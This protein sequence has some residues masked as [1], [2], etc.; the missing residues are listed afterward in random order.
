[1]VRRRRQSISKGFFFN[2]W[3][4]L[5]EDQGSLQW[6]SFLTA[7]PQPYVTEIQA[8]SFSWNLVLHFNNQGYD[9]G[10][11]LSSGWMMGKARSY[12][13]PCEFS[14]PKYLTELPYFLWKQVGVAFFLSDQWGCSLTPPPLYLYVQW[15]QS[16]E[17][18]ILK[19]LSTMMSFGIEHGG[20]ELM[21]W[22]KAQRWKELRL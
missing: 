2:K 20:L 10:S 9:G 14:L 4:G 18:C 17:L 6:D 21:H 12:V 1:M 15:T 7:A 8:A 11:V 3:N 13:E 19:V 5:A 22:G 16:W